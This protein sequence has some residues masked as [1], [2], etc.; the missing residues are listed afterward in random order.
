MIPSPT[1]PANVGDLIPDVTMAV[2]VSVPIPPPEVDILAK[3]A[4]SALNAFPSIL[5]HNLQGIHSIYSSA[6]AAAATAIPTPVV[7]I[8]TEDGKE[9]TKTSTPATPFLPT[10]GVIKALSILM[11]A[12]PNP[13]GV[14]QEVTSVVGGVTSILKSIRLCHGHNG[15]HE[16]C[17]TQSWSNGGTSSKVTPLQKSSI[18]ALLAVPLAR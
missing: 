17:L 3:L 2:L 16:I 18:G 5:M 13:T 11:S 1:V 7:Y 14:L 6:I 9:C 15:A 4:E 12:L 8:T 10:D